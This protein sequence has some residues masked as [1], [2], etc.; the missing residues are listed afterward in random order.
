MSL[1][2][3]TFDGTADELSA[4]VS[5]T[6]AAT[7]GGTMLHPTW[8]AAYFRWQLLCPRP[9]GR[10]YLVAAY[11]GPRLV[12]C[13]L[14][15]EFAFRLHGEPIR[16]TMGSWLTVL[17][18]S[19]RLGVG[20]R[21][22]DD[23][24]ARLLDRGALFSLGYGY[25]GARKSMGPKFWRKQPKHVRFLGR[26]GFWV[27]AL[28]HA[29]LV[30]WP[31]DKSDSFALRAL[32]VIQRPPPDPPPCLH[33]RPYRAADLPDCLAVV[34]RLAATADLGYLWTADRLARQLDFEGT[35]RTLVY[36][37]GGGALGFT[38]YHHLPFVGRTTVQSAV[39]DFFAPG[40]LTTAEQKHLLAATVSAMRREGAAVALLLRLGEHAPLPLLATG[41]I[42]LP[43]DSDL[44]C[45]MAA[46][47]PDP[48]F[49]RVRRVHIHWR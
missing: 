42:P 18:D 8:D 28:D 1:E 45:A 47:D 2:V 9:E 16:G 34:N 27:R 29:K 3:R 13:L 17:S 48:R 6:W 14:A 35:P 12:G 41:F 11:D 25:I 40:T 49:D 20:V 36:D 24:R 33:V 10:D 31:I 7:Y 15:E 23:L 19:R 26:V 21:L 37:R 46:T 32:S 43:P 30:E 22:F 5:G 38:N 44:I 4:F 39:L